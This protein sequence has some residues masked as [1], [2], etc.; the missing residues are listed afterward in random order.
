MISTTGSIWAIHGYSG[1][2]DHSPF[3]LSEFS[4]SADMHGRFRY[5]MLYIRTIADS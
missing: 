2:P 4:F 1:I 3:L 5:G